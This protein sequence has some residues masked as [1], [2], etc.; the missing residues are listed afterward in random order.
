MWP[1]VILGHKNIPVRSVGCYV[2]GEKFPMVA[3]AHMSVLTASVAGVPRFIASA[4]PQNGEPHPAIVTAMHLGGG[5]EIYVPG[6][7]QAVGAMAIGTETVEP[8]H[9]LVGPGNAFVAEAKRQLSFSDA[10][11]RPTSRSLLLNMIVLA[12]LNSVAALLVTAMVMPTASGWGCVPAFRPP[13]SASTTR[14]AA[15]IR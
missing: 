1:G 14:S 15:T 8:V 9:M 2:P 3:S 11:W 6:G 13:C 4:P 10:S 12:N 5:H 7:V